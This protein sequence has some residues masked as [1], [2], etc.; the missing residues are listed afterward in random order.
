MRVGYLGSFHHL[1]HR[2][3]FH[4][5]RDVVEDGVVEEYGL[6]V[7]VSDERSER[8]DFQVADVGPVYGDASLVEVVVAGY[9]VDEGG[10]SRTRLS[11]KRHSLPLGY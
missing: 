7:H 6:L 11:H 10:L 2:S 8:L 1:L 5:E 4:T 9:E 3:T